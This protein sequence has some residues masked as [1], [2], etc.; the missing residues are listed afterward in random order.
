MA[1]S[2]KTSSR[3]EASMRVVALRPSAPHCALCWQSPP[4]VLPPRPAMR[5]YTALMTPALAPALRDKQGLT[6]IIRVIRT[7]KTH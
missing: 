4:A 6:K 3:L 5:P 7:S 2:Q 1:V